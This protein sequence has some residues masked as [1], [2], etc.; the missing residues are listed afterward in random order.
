[1]LKG[2]IDV[3]TDLN[4]V[5]NSL[6]NFNGNTKVII[7]QDQPDPSI[8]SQCRGVIGSV[9]LPPYECFSL[10]LNDD[11][12]FMP[13]YFNY[14]ATGEAYDFIL[15]ILRALYNGTNLILYTSKGE[16][17]NFFSEFSSFM[18]SSFG[19]LI[20][21]PEKYTSYGFDI[22]YTPVVCNHLYLSNY[23]TF[24]EYMMNYPKEPQFII[25]NEVIYKMVEE[26]N[27]YVKMP[28][29]EAYTRYFMDYK[30]AVGK[31]NKPLQIVL[32]RG[33]RC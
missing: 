17:Q 24:E 23:M 13:A 4:H 16:Y 25:P 27:P 18:F 2:S 33:D 1:M 12:N 22:N 8:V 20:G 26:T 28:S 31:Y 9:L 5:M 29:L 15:V 30:L 14:L 21:E 19:L 11:P 6:Y 32:R 10:K 3:M 7:L